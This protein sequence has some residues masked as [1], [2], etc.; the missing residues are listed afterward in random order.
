[1]K[2]LRKG[3]GFEGQFR[4]GDAGRPRVVIMTTDETNAEERAIRMQSA[5]SLLVKAQRHAEAVVA[6]NQLARARNQRDFAS[7]EA[8]A[9]KMAETSPEPAPA[10]GPVTFRDVNELWL[11]GALRLI[12]KDAVAF[13]GVLSVQNTRGLMNVILPILGDM[14]VVAITLADCDKIKHKIAQMDIGLAQRKKYC[15]TVRQVFSYAVEPLRLITHPPVSEG[16]VPKGQE[17]R[18]AFQMLYPHED[19][20]FL[21]CADVAILVRFYFG[22]MLR[23]GMRPGE[24][25]KL[26]WRDWSASIGKI[27][28]DNTKT[29][30]PRS[31]FV[32]DDVAATLDAL[33]PEGAQPEDLVFAEIRK[34][35]AHVV[36]D[37]MHPALRAAGLDKLRPELF[38]SE[39]MR[40]WIVAHDCRATYVTLKAAL[41]A[42]EHEIMSVTGH[43]T[44][45]EINTYKREIG[46]LEKQV[47]LG[48]LAWFQPL[49]VLLGLRAAEPSGAGEVARGVARVINLS[50]KR[51]ISGSPART[52]EGTLEGAENANSSQKR[53]SNSRT[54]GAVPPETGGVAQAGGGT[55]RARLVAAVASA[56]VAGDLELANWLRA[57]LDALAGG[58]R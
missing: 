42:T 30:T 32:D 52:S 1:M 53:P 27:N 56:V 50:A 3:G 6:L 38:V 35:L 41:G 44:S 22:L 48:R 5:V 49:D 20:V 21:G 19:E 36:D 10:T 58:A 12:D 26:Q 54:R 57:E 17:P 34:S 14:P 45:K 39:G 15:R 43:M 25:A 7:I 16:W 23:T 4:C 29:K 47:K 37:V 2:L 46:E 51:R 40:R 13:K 18:K 33:R 9:R 24:A 28:L 31:F 8:A 11:S 55:D